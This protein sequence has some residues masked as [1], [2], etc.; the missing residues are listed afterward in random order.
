[1]KASWLI[2]AIFSVSV[3][4]AGVRNWKSIRSKLIH[5]TLVRFRP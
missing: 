1:M 3:V 4:L 5:P 2:Y